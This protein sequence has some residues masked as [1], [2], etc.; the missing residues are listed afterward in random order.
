[1][2][3]V[4]SEIVFFFIRQLYFYLPALIFYHF[5][6]MCSSAERGNANNCFT[7]N[8]KVLHRFIFFFRFARAFPS[9]MQKFW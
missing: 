2:E 7:K 1:M 5:N 6:G 3:M 9:F 4:T 8:K